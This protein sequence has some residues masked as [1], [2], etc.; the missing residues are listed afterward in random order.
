MIVSRRLFAILAVAAGLALCQFW[1]QS[2]VNFGPGANAGRPLRHLPALFASALALFLALALLAWL[3]RAAWLLSGAGLSSR[4]LALVEVPPKLH[5]AVCPIGVERVECFSDAASTALCIGW[6]RPRIL[7]S[8]VLVAE[9][10]EAEL[11]AVLLHEQDHARR[12]EPLRRAL[13]SAG[14]DVFFLLPL[15]RWWSRHQIENSELQADRAAMERLGRRPLARAFA[16]QRTDP[17]IR[18]VFFGGAAQ[19]RAAQLL[20]DPLPKR[21]PP[22]DVCRA[23][24]AGAMLAALIWLC[25]AQIVVGLLPTS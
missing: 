14:A 19:L 24:V 12:W 6:L 16:M 3:G 15:L 17:S 11:Q 8:T 25:L 10:G 5:R 2:C 9:L 23:T 1:L 13:R 22:V 4:R 21:R 7:I 20:G 18:A